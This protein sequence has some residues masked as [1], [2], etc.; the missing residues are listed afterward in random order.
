M[1]RRVC[2]SLGVACIFLVLASCAGQGGRLV[3]AGAGVRVFDLRVDT[4]LDWARIR[5]PR[6]EYWTIDGLPLNELV[7]VSAVKPGEH[8][9]LAARERTRR[10]DG[11]WYRSGMRPDEIQD[12]ILDG[13]RQEGWTQVVASGLRPARF[14]GSPG[15]R[16]EANLT[17]VGGLRYRGMFGAVVR[18]GRLSHFLWLAPAEHYYPRDASAVARMFDSMIFVD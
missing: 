7:F 15:L 12:V 11:P 17:H 14:G 16:F 5:Q 2:L 10:P 3:P 6:M 8:V 9:F 13:L 4:S 18:N 1:I